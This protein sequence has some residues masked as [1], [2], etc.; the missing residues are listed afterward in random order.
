MSVLNKN[1]YGYISPSDFNLFAKQAQ[2][3]LFENYFYSYNYQIVKE[4][5]RQSGTEY[6]DITKGLEEVIN[7]FSETKFLFHQY[8]NKF[9]TPSQTTT[10]D[11]YYLLNKVLIYTKQL[12]QG[13][14]TAL[15]IQ[16]LIDN[17]ATFVSDGVQV[18]DIVVNLSSNPAEAG[19]VSA[20]V[21]ETVLTL[22]DGNGN[23][24]DSFINPQMQYL[25]YSSKPVKEAEK[26]TNSKI[27]ML[28]NSLL[29][30]PNLMFP[31]YSQQEPTLFLFPDSI[32][33]FGAVECQYIRFPKVPKWTYVDLVSGEPAFNQS[34]NDFQ[35]FELPKDDEPNLVNKILQYAGMSI[36][37]MS[38]AQFGGAEEAKNMQTEK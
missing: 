31:A 13:T 38:A 3:D 14:N 21:S 7:T 18:G 35:D 17:T 8:N 4:N 25:I 6:A 24:F 12:A 1:N 15:Q 33:T 30:A 26:V 9:F 32:N 28:N 2:L 34:A 5:A 22:V 11:D 10:G 19:Y 23:P 27:T 36:R 29:T 20:V 37:E 16:T